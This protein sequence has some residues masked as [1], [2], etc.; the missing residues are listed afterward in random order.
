MRRNPERPSIGRVQVKDLSNEQKLQIRDQWVEYAKSGFKLLNEAYLKDAD[1]SGADLRSVTLF[2][3][4]LEGANLSDARLLFA[5]LRAAN[6][7]G[8]NLE[9]ANL[10]KA[11]L[12][13]AKLQGAQLGG[14]NL[15]GANL[16][17]AKF[18]GANLIGANLRYANLEYTDLPNYF[19][20]LRYVGLTDLSEIKVEK[21]NSNGFFE[22]RKFFRDRGQDEFGELLE[23][24]IRAEMDQVRREIGQ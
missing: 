19:K 14:A 7:T 11:E 8:A 5:D 16:E 22:L 2:G 9:G 24:E 10:R 3:V 18:Q 15:E 23:L 21:S 20:L 1:L 12:D 17:W 13:G 4:N 6:F